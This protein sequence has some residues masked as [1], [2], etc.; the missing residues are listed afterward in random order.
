MSLLLAASPAP[1][2]SPRRSL[3]SGRWSRP[4]SRTFLKSSL[5]VSRS[6]LHGT[7]HSTLTPFPS[8]SSPPTDASEQELAALK[9]DAFVQFST[10]A[11]LVKAAALC[12]QRQLQLSTEKK[13]YTS[14]F[15]A[16]VDTTGYLSQRASRQRKW[17][18]EQREQAAR[19]AAEAEARRQRELEL[20]AERRRKEEEEEAERRRMEKEQRRE[21]RRRKR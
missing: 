1:G 11:E 5:P 17:E 10:Q 6:L 14:P 19:A 9:R 2:C 4:A 20:Q 16:E 15:S 21:E 3:L 8:L 12:C 7:T 13:D 18:Q